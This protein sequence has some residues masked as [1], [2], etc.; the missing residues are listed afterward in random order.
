MLF[1]QKKAHTFFIFHMANAH[2]R[3]ANVFQ[4]KTSPK[5]AHDFFYFYVAASAAMPPPSLSACYDGGMW[6]SA[7]SLHGT[8]PWALDP[9][10][11][12]CN[13]TV[14]PM[15]PFCPRGFLVSHGGPAAWQ[16]CHLLGPFHSYGG[17]AALLLLKIGIMPCLWPCHMATMPPS[18]LCHLAVVLSTTLLYSQTTPLFVEF[19]PHIA[20]VIGCALWRRPLDAGFGY[21]ATAAFHSHLCPFHIAIGHSLDTFH[22]YLKAWPWCQPNAHCF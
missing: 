17:P 21:Y 18:W 15:W 6:P 11:W 20:A 8:A 3:K 10:A 4:E 22:G 13:L 14:T 1:A 12:Y 7:Y 19:G 2:W 5:K 16:P 9:C